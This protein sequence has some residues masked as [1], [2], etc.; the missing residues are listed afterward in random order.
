MN[1]EAGNTEKEPIFTAQFSLG[2]ESGGKIKDGALSCCNSPHPHP[3]PPPRGEGK[4]K[5]LNGKVQWH[6]LRWPQDKWEEAGPEEAHA[7]FQ[8]LGT[9]GRDIRAVVQKG[10]GVS[11]TFNSFTATEIAL[12]NSSSKTGDSHLV[13]KQSVGA[14][15]QPLNASLS[16]TELPT[17]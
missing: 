16:R 2:L 15:G 6:L 10:S 4:D 9:G 5:E 13:P 14:G 7:R 3:P 12:S 8:G 11:S 17:A 1:H